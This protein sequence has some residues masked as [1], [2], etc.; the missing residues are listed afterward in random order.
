LNGLNKILLALTKLYLL[1]LPNILQIHG[2]STISRY[3]MCDFLFWAGVA[4]TKNSGTRVWLVS[5][6]DQGINMSH[7]MGCERVVLDVALD[8]LD[9]ERAV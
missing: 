8:N 5:Y 9:T 2:I 6:W 3:G 4:V 7:K 1:N